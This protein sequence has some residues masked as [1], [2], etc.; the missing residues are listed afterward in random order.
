MVLPHLLAHEEDIKHYFSQDQLGGID[1]VSKFPCTHAETILTGFHCQRHI[2]ALSHRMIGDMMT[3]YFREQVCEVKR[4]RVSCD[5]APASS[6]HSPLTLLQAHPPP[7]PA[8][9][10]LWPK[11]D[12]L[13][14]LPR[15]KVHKP[16]SSS[17]GYP[18]VIHG[19]TLSRFHYVV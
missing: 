15:L 8:S 13:G 17:A 11:G 14:E 5:Q 3:L 6:P 19:E 2:S 18:S 1:T 4:R 9:G 10:S 12:Q 16:V 7:E